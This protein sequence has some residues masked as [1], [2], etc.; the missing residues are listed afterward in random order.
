MTALLSWLS[1]PAATIGDA[2]SREALRRQLTG[3]SSR[4]YTN[5]DLPRVVL[6]PPPPVA[7]GAE[8]DGEVPASAP[9]R[10]ERWWR[11]RMTTARDDLQRD[12]VLTEAVQAQVNKLTTDIVA[13]NDPLQQSQLRG[14]LQ[15]AVIELDRLQKQVITHRKT[16]DSLHDEARRLGVPA[17]WLR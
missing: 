6:A 8:P 3:K 17:G 9:R 10:D 5:Q 15:K 13:A 12:E 11:D 1:S 7:A 2:A 16:I 14:Q 4:L